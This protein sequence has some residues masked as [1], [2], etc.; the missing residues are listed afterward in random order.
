MTGVR[1]PHDNALMFPVASIFFGANGGEI[2]F[3]PVHVWASIFPAMHFAQP[4]D[5]GN[6]AGRYRFE[7]L[8]CDSRYGGF[9]DRLWARR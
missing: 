1:F 2:G 3:Q 9:E 4:V 6:Q 8:A 5:S 7:T